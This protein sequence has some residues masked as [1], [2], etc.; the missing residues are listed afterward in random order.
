MGANH[1]IL[2][3]IPID[4]LDVPALIMDPESVK[5]VN[6][7]ER[8]GVYTGDVATLSF[9]ERHY[10]KNIMLDLSQ[11]IQ[12]VR[13]SVPENHLVDFVELAVKAC[14]VYGELSEW[15]SMEEEVFDTYDKDDFKLGMRNS[16]LALNAE[17]ASIAANENYQSHLDDILEAAWSL[18]KE[19]AIVYVTDIVFK[20][21]VYNCP[22]FSSGCVYRPDEFIAGTDTLVFALNFDDA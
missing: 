5:P 15:F 21:Q 6:L 19:A 13:E 9:L 3:G 22:S 10:P 11:S 20:L 12:R 1:F 2:T 4:E 7:D 8:L 16:N 14:R 17:F 18:Y